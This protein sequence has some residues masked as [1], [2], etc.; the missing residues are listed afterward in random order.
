MREPGPGEVLV[1][2][3]WTS[4]DPG[5]RLRLAER[6]PAGYFAPFGLRE[7][8][9]GIM[10]IGEVVESRADGFAA[11]DAVWHASG[12]RDY[13]VLAADADA[14]RLGT[15]TRLDTSLVPAQRYL[16]PLGGMGLTAY[17]GLFDVAGL[18]TGDVVVGPPPERRKPRGAVRQA[19]RPSRHRQRVREEGL[20][21]A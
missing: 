5:L 4:V 16:G 8:M 19:S 11:G 1:R 21:P 13:A 9:D 12:W 18:R 14:R 6:G 15:L 10:T 17:A 20:L 2:N 3:T 7:P